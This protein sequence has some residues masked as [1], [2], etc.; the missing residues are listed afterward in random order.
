M[1]KY[2]A[3]ADPT[4][5]EEEAVL[6]VFNDKENWHQN[7][8]DKELAEDYANE[9][10]EILR[11]NEIIEKYLKIQLD[12]SNRHPIDSSYSPKLIVDYIT[13]T[14][15]KDKAWE[16]SPNIVAGEDNFSVDLTN[17]KFP[18]F[19][20]FRREENYKGE[21][22]IIMNSGVSEHEE[23]HPEYS[24]QMYR[25]LESVVDRLRIGTVIDIGA[26][27]DY[28][29]IKSPNAST[30]NYMMNLL[31]SALQDIGWV[32]NEA[33]SDE[34]AIDNSAFPLKVE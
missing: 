11:G 13:E 3:F 2:F 16:Y 19:F 21:E 14:L 6:I 27:E 34:T 25:E 33:M 31:Y 7:L 17:V 12:G 30:N 10:I 4:G 28:H 22:E 29:V 15:L 8:L 23:T 24:Y 5:N 20:S 32:Y 1:N 18:R 9:L 26:A